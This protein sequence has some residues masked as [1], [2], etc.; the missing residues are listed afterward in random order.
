MNTRYIRIRT[1]TGSNDDVDFDAVEY[2]FCTTTNDSDCTSGEG[3]A[4]VASATNDP[5]NTANNA[6]GNP[7]G[8]F[9]RI[10]N[11]GDRL[12]IDLTDVVPAGENYNII[13]RRKFS[14]NNTAFADIVI[15]ESSDLTNWTTNPVVPSTDDRVNF[16]TTT[17][18]AT[19]NL[20]P[21]L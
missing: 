11:V 4:I 1:L 13:W 9:T 10:Y 3:D 6:L 7:D 5:T 12:T 16:I 17:L 18:T 8:N 19:V 14:Y 20:S 2:D 21:T 15:E